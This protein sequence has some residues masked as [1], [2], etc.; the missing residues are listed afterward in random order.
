MSS[1]PPPG[2]PIGADGY[3]VHPGTPAEQPGAA[4]AVE[5]PAPIRLAIR[6]MWVGAALS[7]AGLV[8][9]LLTLDSLKSQLRDS[10]EKSDPNYT[11]SDFDALYGISVGIAVVAALIGVSLWAWMAWKNGQGR[12]WAR[13]VATV[14]GGLNLL[15]TLSAVSLGNVTG[16]SIAVSVVGLVLA[17]VIL[18]LLW[19]KESS[20]FYAARSRPQWG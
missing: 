2:G 15:S 6:L 17:L 9:S 14:L 19:R 16:A 4:A 5:Q 11:Q 8:V 20:E 13:I 1:T 3:P 18:S 12:P 7:L 10:L